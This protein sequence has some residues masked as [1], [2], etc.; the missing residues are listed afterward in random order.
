MHGNNFKDLTGHKYGR[1]TVKSF[2]GKRGAGGVSA[3]LCACDCGSEKIATTGGLTSGHVGSCGCLGAEVRH[4][5][6]R[7]HGLSN[8]HPLY[9]LWC[10]MRKR[11][12]N[13][14]TDAYPHYGGRGISVC[15]RWSDFTL[16]LADMEPTWRPGLTIDRIDPNGNYGP[17]NCRW[18]TLLE[19]ANNRRNNL[20]IPTP[21]GEMSIS[22]ASRRFAVPL[23]RMYARHHRGWSAERLLEPLH[24]R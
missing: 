22:E 14:A 5:N 12:T 11:C 16:F 2:H 21:A 3:W 23:N 7:S 17:D 20:I 4:T 15:E 8:K 6:T 1:L 10:G 18:A 24:V 9:G 19:Q 13:P